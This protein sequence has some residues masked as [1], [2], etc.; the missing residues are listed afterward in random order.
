M[1]K[2][3]VSN[4]LTGLPTQAILQSYPQ[5]IGIIARGLGPLLFELSF[6]GVRSAPPWG[7]HPI[8]EIR[9]RRMVRFTNMKKI[10]PCPSTLI[11]SCLAAFAL[12]SLVGCSDDERQSST[13]ESSSATMSTDSKDMSH[14]GDHNSH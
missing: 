14:R 8:G 7:V 10:C 13:T 11:L 1:I 4:I 5:G 9:S 3:Q 2:L 12:A 6:G